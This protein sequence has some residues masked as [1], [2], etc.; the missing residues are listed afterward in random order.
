MNNTLDYI[1]E[2]AKSNPPLNAKLKVATD[3]TNYFIDGTGTSNEVSIDDSPSDCTI[4][5]KEDVLKKLIDGKL[6]STMAVLMGQIKI[7]GDMGIALKLQTI[8]N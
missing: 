2:K 7:Q 4:T 5:C 3:K 1:K 8:I 6:S